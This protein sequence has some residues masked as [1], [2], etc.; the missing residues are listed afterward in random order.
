MHEDFKQVL[1]SN[2]KE[3]M[4][5]HLTEHPEQFDE[6][7]AL[8]LGDEDPFCWR[9][10]FVIY[11]VMDHNDPRVAP[12]ISGIVQVLPLKKDGHQRELLKILLKTELEEEHEGPLFD[13]CISIWQS[14]RKKPS[15][16]FTAFRFLAQMAKKYPELTHE[17]LELAQPQY[18][19][20]LSP[21][22]RNAAQRLLRELSEY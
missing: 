6:A 15:V 14:I 19:N 21:G 2:F 20:A 9:S 22:I 12:H 11:D 4:V 10:A 13:H 7:M 1:I 8:A 18:V 16:R 17:V 3:G 5:R